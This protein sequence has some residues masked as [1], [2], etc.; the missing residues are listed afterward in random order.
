MRGAY[1][2]I[3]INDGK[4]AI[5]CISDIFEPNIKWREFKEAKFNKSWDYTFRQ[6]YFSYTNN[7]MSNQFSPVLTIA[8]VDETGGHIRNQDLWIDKG[9]VAHILY[10][11]RNIWE[12]AIRD[13]FFPNTPIKMSLNYCQISEGHIVYRRTLLEV[14]ETDSDSNKKT[15]ATFVPNCAGFHSPNGNDLYVLYHASTNNEE[16]I[17]YIKVFPTPSEEME[18]LPC[19]TPLQ[20]FVVA[21]SRNGT[22]PSR[23]ID[24]LGTAPGW[25]YDDVPTPMNNDSKK[26]TKD[27]RFVELRYCKYSIG[28]D[29]AC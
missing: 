16:H 10:I 26:E 1:P 3:A 14:T 15:Y 20:S 23:I 9:G 18:I 13:E 2:Q 29:N 25:K 19:N 5:L 22:D 21:S 17:F 6:L 27:Y 11:Q 4:A 8:S 12:T 24:L 28:G 7:I